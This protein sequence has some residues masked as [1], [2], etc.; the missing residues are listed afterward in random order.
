MNLINKTFNL[1]NKTLPTIEEVQ[2]VI[3]LDQSDWND[4]NVNESLKSLKIRSKYIENSFPILTHEFMNAIKSMTMK[5]KIKKIAELHCGIGWLTHWLK[6]YNVSISTS[7]D[8]MSWKKHKNK[9]M[10]HVNKYDSIEYVKSHPEIDLYI[11]SWPYMDDTA[12]NI[13]KEIHS[14]QY[15]LYI[16]EHQ[17]GCTA[18]DNFFENTYKNK[19]KDKWKLNESF[20]SF[21]GI[22]DRP[23]LFRK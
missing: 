5:L 14:G 21:W 4:Y 3:L 1:E 17:G 19:I 12:T 15:L 10:K 9:H 11:L 8:N 22:H 6:K 7:I 13:W 16:G 20:V 18:N 2:S 23:I